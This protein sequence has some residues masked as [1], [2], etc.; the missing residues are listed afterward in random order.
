MNG[1]ISEEGIRRDLAWMH[2]V[3]IGGVTT[4]DISID[5][6][7]VVDHRLAYMTTPWKHAFA[8]ATQLTN[9][10]GMESAIAS[11]PGWNE[12]G[13]PWVPAAEG[14]KKYVWSQTRVEGG[15]PFHGVLPSP[16][17]NSG[18]FQDM[19]IRDSPLPSG[20]APIPSFYADAAV[21][22]YRVTP[23]EAGDSD[24]R[25]VISSSDGALDAT[26]VDDGHFDKATS[27]AIPE[28]GQ[29]W[30]T[31]SFAHKKTLRAVTYALVEPAENEPSYK[32]LQ[33]SD[34]GRLF[35][36][37]IRLDSGK[38][39]VTIGNAPVHTISFLP[40]SARYFRVSISRLAPG[41][42]VDKDSDALKNNAVKVFEIALRAEPTINHFQEKAGFGTERDL[43]KFPTPAF[44]GSGVIHRGDV[45]DL[46]SKLGSNGALNWTPPAGHWKIVRLGYSLMG[47]AN[48]PT[49]AEASGLEVDKLDRRFTEHYLDQYLKSYQ[50]A[51]GADLMGAKGI[52]YMLNDSWEV[53]TQ[54]WT[55]RILIRFRELRGYDATPWL[56]VLTGQVV[57]S[58]AASDRFLWD[59]RKT[60]ADLVTSEHYGA[61]EDILHR[62]HMQHYGESHEVTRVY[63]ADG[64]QVKKFSEVPMGAMWTGKPHVNDAPLGY[65]ADDRESASV[66]HLYGQN[67]AAAES[68]TAAESP[69]GWS[70]ATLKPTADQEFLNGINRIV[71]H[72]SAHQPMV[73]E[74]QVPGL[75]LG[76]Y[77]QWFNRN[78]TWA[79]DAG[80]WL[81][82]LARS[83]YML[84]QGRFDADIL[85]FYGEDSNITALF[86]E[87]PPRIPDGYNFD[88]VNAD[89][90]MHQLSASPGEIRAASGI[91][92]RL[93]VLDAHARQM[94]LP[95]LRALVRLLQDGATIV[96]A[97]PTDDPSLGDD[98]AEFTRLANEAFG[99]GTGI[100]HVGKGVV[101]AGFGLEQA[102]EQVGLA[103]DFDYD[104]KAV[105]AKIPFLHRKLKDGDIYFLD[106]RSDRPVTF[107][108]SFRVAG[109]APAFFRAETG[110]TL[111][112]PFDVVD[113][114]TRVRVMLEP[115]G[116]TFVVLRTATTQSHRAL[117]SE[118]V[119]HT[120]TVD[121]P[122][123][124]AFPGGWGAPAQTT[125]PTLASWTDLPETGIRYFSGT[126]SY[127]RT[128]DV[129][130][131]SL[132]PG[133]RV[134]LDLGNVRELAHVWMNGKDLGVS[135][136]APFTVDVTGAL[137]AGHNELEVRVTNLWVNRLIGDQQPGA[138]P[139]TYAD[140]HPYNASS[141]LLPSGL[142]GPVTIQFLS[143]P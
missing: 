18:A 25:A 70:P 89:A 47:I 105:T 126:A 58:P 113:G 94:S 114:R 10:Y 143:S 66:A 83:S 142:L 116:T 21:F 9:S 132:R 42:T 98:Q 14:M 23:A 84:Q 103:A 29:A 1:N 15:I 59:W 104:R 96:G 123:S 46:T 121:G 86:D 44:A 77:G 108:G 55:D 99:D 107:D 56:P 20:A 76:P 19:G 32:V 35:R 64:M 50:D 118:S 3:G 38:T 135:W 6:P 5:T 133:Q 129:P 7:Q 33:A 141:P 52:S 139:L 36:P 39:G 53:G 136:H 91:P 8:L 81:S 71:I 131:A 97:K 80:P 117:A 17:R 48:H 120:M 122:W 110:A 137:K 74:H 119:G 31:W 78:E 72:E 2:S 63:V 40:V 67:I 51:V 12:T 27:I 102:I 111:P 62:W 34:D 140:V 93:L 90:L 22:A 100:H 57:D 134:V 41:G 109:K 115:W 79:L 30:I 85:Y 4:I 87:A 112:A 101:Y 61:I 13:G 68:M 11:S 130:K 26:R 75:T 37:V 65:I 125:F 24:N 92:Y 124:V 69:W 106:N 28:T 95:V 128:I 49:T 16:P 73:G 82:Y 45:V 60:L 54:N 127:K 138:K 43:S 88:Y